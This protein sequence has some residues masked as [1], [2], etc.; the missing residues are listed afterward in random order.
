MEQLIL[1]MQH[2]SENTIHVKLIVMVEVIGNLC[3][4]IEAASLPQ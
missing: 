2:I 3:I 1:E 4:I